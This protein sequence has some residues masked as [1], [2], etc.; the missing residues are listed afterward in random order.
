[1]YIMYLNMIL[2]HLPL[3]KMAAIVANNIFKCILLKE[4]DQ[5]MIQI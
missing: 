3:D 5:I 2:T 4:N 1:M